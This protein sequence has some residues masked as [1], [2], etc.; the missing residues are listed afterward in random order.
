MNNLEIIETQNI[1]IKIQSEIINDLFLEIMNY[2]SVEEAD[3]MPL[4]SKINDV[5]KLKM[6]IE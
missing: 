6:K 2:K 5:A 4:V 1:I 3:N